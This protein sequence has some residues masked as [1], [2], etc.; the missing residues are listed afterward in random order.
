LNLDDQNRDRILRFLYQRHKT[1]RGINK[2]PIGIRDLQSEMKKQHQ[3]SQADV[4][5]NLDYLIQTGWVRE[6]VKERA[7]TTKAGMEVSAE[8][9]KYKISDVGINHLEAGTV[10]KRPQAASQ[11][12]ITNIKGVT[13][14]GDGNIVNTEFTDLSR[15]IDELDRA[16]AD[17][18]SLSD[19]QKLDAAADLS[20]IQ[21]QIA[22]KNPDRSIVNAAW[23]ALN[24]VA[25]VDGVLGAFEKV[26]RLIGGL[27][28]AG[29]LG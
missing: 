1:T 2:I 4:S 27:L 14:L 12:N 28:G 8:Q 11:I 6:V 21:S 19:E 18:K 20:T 24:S 9:C 16:I 26:G 3:M 29:G 5:S 7:F 13:I 10:F 25:T 23:S 15:A 17:S 22:K